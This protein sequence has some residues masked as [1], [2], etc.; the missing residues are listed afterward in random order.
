MRA[1]PRSWLPAALV[2]AGLVVAAGCGRDDGLRV[3]DAGAP[4]APSVTPT[5]QGSDPG[6]QDD[7]RTRTPAPEATVDLAEVR[8]TLLADRSLDPYSRRVLDGCT[9]V[10]RCLERGATVNVLRSAHPQVVVRIHTLDKFVFGAFLIAVE[11][12]GPRRVWSLK[13]DQVKVRPSPQG[14]LVVE[15]EIFA[16]AD[17]PC[18]PSVTRVEVFRWNGRQM[19]KVSSRDQEGD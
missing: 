1:R 13:A 8:R 2:L 15:S 10:T 18:C 19:I 16:A 11:P 14:D 5:A 7:R 9:V 17:K 4:P 12:T 3:E 6:I